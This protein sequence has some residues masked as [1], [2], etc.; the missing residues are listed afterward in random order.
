MYD[1]FSSRFPLSFLPF[2]LLVSH[3]L[4]FFLCHLALDIVWIRARLAHGMAGVGFVIF[5]V[6]PWRMVHRSAA[7][8]SIHS[9]CT[10]FQQKG[11]T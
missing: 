9:P 4:V 2:G 10:L 6:L 3:W 1:T 11:R 5:R 7:M 8:L